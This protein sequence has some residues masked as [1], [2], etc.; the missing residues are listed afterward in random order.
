M[1]EISAARMTTPGIVLFEVAAPDGD[2]RSDL[3]TSLTPR[4]RVLFFAAGERIC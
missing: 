1:G 4:L 2:L 3:T